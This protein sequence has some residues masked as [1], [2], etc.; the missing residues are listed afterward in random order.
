MCPL[1]TKTI[2]VWFYVATGILL[3]EVNN[4]QKN[5]YW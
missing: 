3:S 1:L 5:G 4:K 2:F